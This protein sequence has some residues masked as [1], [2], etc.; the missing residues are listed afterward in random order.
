VGL[1]FGDR[2]Q[3]ESILPRAQSSD[4][5]ILDCLLA[6]DGRAIYAH[7]AETGDSYKVCGLPALV[8]IA[9]LMKGKTGTLLDYQT[10]RE[11]ATSSAVTY[12]AAMFGD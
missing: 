4:R 11:P 10:Y 8:L 5:R 7:A 12:A 2:V 6:G 9:E 1:K 3:A